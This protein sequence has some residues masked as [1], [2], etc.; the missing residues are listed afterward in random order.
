M[1]KIKYLFG[2]Y[3]IML[4]LILIF[5]YQASI[6]F[7]MSTVKTTKVIHDMNKEMFRKNDSILKVKDSIK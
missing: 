6:G 1:T 5:F 7:G 2:L 4:V 3:I